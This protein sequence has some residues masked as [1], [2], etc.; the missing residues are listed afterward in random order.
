MRIKLS[1]PGLC[2]FHMYVPANE[3]LSLPGSY[4]VQS[5]QIPHEHWL[6]VPK[7]VLVFVMWVHIYWDLTYDHQIHLHVW[8][9]WIF[10]S[11]LLLI[12]QD[13]ALAPS[14]AS[15][16]WASE[17][18]I[19]NCKNRMNWSQEKINLGPSN[20]FGSI[21]WTSF[22]M[23]PQQPEDDSFFFRSWLLAHISW[24]EM[25]MSVVNAALEKKR[26]AL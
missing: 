14:C 17:N 1:V 4:V 15:S 9:T 10:N 25:L 26:P 5:M 20:D 16:S 3:S 21:C 23:S 12:T 7:N 8:A 18:L 2:K 19:I 11:G 13:Y 24:K 6:S 22:L